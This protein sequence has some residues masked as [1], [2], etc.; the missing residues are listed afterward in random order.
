MEKGC[1]LDI[2]G[3]FEVMNEW[4]GYYRLSVMQGGDDQMFVYCP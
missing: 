1:D 4:V 3:L 2:R